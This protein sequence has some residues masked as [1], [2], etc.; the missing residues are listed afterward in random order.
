[1]KKTVVIILFLFTC[2]YGSAQQERQNRIKSLKIAFI[3]E[4]L[5]LTTAEAQ[6]FWPIYNNYDDNTFRLKNVELKK[7]RNE[8][9]SR[10]IDNMSEQESKSVLDRIESI[11]D[12]IYNERKRLVQRLLDVIPAKKI[13]LLKKVE[14]DF[15]RELLQRLRERRM[16]RFQNRN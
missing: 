11:E 13:I 9:L 3:T 16:Q 7:I 10:G 5:A 6:R 1:M 2:L 12:G 14:D 8:I 15:N 4:K